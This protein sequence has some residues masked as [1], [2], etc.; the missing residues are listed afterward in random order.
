MLFNLISRSEI[1]N[2]I[3][4]WIEYAALLIEI[5]AVAIIVIAIIVALGRW[6]VTSFAASSGERKRTI[7]I[8]SRSAWEKRCYWV[9]RFSSRLT[10]SARSRWKQPWKVLSCW[11][12][13]C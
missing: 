3:L 1:G 5:L 8:N 10:S 4:V 2:T 12:Y 9:W 11:D 6:G 7:T 13:W